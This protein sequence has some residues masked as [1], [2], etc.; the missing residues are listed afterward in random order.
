MDGMRQDV[1]PQGMENIHSRFH[2]S[3]AVRVGC[4]LYISGQVGRNEQLQIVDAGNPP[5]EEG[6]ERQF[7]QCFENVKRVLSA[8][9]ATF[10][11]VFEIETWFTDMPSMLKIF[12]KVKDKYFLGPQYPT[13]T[14]FGVSH[15]SSPG[16][17]CEI[18][19]KALL[20]QA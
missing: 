5:T 19:C 16:L 6:L 11:D 7:T 20:R 17:H 8:A 9:G 14:G 3:P 12:M 15:F 2:Y 4:V 18:K 13:W 1:V 10:N